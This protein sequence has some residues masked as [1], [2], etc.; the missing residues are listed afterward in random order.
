MNAQLLADLMDALRITPWHILAAGAVVLV[1]GLA[2]FTAGLLVGHAQAPENLWRKAQDAEIKA[3][4]FYADMVATR[5]ELAAAHA[6][7]AK[8]LGRVALMN[9]ADEEPTE[10][11]EHVLRIAGRKR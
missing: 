3:K 9:Q 11:E 6:K 10:E 8:L 1:A 5:R 2:I 4:T 7:H